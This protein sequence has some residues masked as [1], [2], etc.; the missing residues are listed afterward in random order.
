VGGALWPPLAQYWIDLYGWRSAYLCVAAVCLITM[1]P[2]AWLLRRRAPVNPVAMQPPV[3]NAVVGLSGAQ[4]QTLL[5]LAGLACCMAMAMP[6]VHIVAYCSDLGFGAARGAQMLSLMLGCGIV[7]RLASGYIADRIGGVK[8]LLLGSS[9]QCLALALFI[10]FNGL[11]ALYMVSILFGLF[12]GGIVPSYPLVVREFFPS[13][14]AGQRT[15]LIIFATL[16]GMAVGGWASG[17]IFDHTGSYRAAFIHGVA[18]NL[19]NI[20]LVA[21]LLRR[22]PILKPT[23]NS[24]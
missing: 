3:S 1:L 8:T 13:N 12:Q 16:V 21:M 9:L 15:G 5:C 6:Q 17:W 24:V 23:A 11:G 14:Q 18:W 22:R 19:V 7:S 4:L 10:P 20:A 2:L